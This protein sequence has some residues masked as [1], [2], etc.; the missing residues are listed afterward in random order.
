MRINANAKINLALDVGSKRDDG[1]HNVSMIMQEISLCD[2]LDIEINDTGKISL[3][4]ESTETGSETDNIAYKAAKTFF[5]NT[6]IQKGCKIVLEKHIPVC[7]GLGGGSSDAAAVLR[8]LNS[9]LGYPLSDDEL[10]SLGLSLGADVPFCIMGKTALAEGIGEK[11]TKL[12][13]IVPKWLALIKP[14]INIST[15]EAYRKIDS[16]S[17]PHPDVAAC[18]ES[19]LRGDME[20]LYKNAGN[21]F[22]YAT[23]EASVK[24][25][26]E[27]MYSMGASFSMMSGSGPTVYGIFDSESEARKAYESYKG[28]FS[29]GGVAQFCV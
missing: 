15:G 10:L 12:G 24:A 9:E 25:I 29:G 5:D 16:C 2:Y 17:Y 6:K 27:H 3:F 18:A 4:T 21:S 22:E 28:S 7:A 20:S 13:G 19:I 1:Y 23:D 26:K 14:D 11:L 8:F